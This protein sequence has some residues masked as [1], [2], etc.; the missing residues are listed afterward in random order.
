MP[1][2]KCIFNERWLKHPEYVSWLECGTDKYSAK[3]NICLKIFDISN[4]GEPAIRSHG[5]GSKHKQ[6]LEQKKAA[7]GCT[8]RDFFSGSSKANE[9]QGSTAAPTPTQPKPS[10]APLT[11]FVSR[12]DCLT[13]EVL[14]TL[15]V[16]NSHNSFNSCTDVSSLFAQMFPDSEIAKHFSCGERKCA[17]MCNYGIAPYFKHQLMKKNSDEDGYVLLF[18]ESLNQNTKNKQ[19]D[20]HARIWEKDQVL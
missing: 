4:M 5:K 16:V 14:W 20:I 8:I 11:S 6:L 7:G 19:M 1:P 10:T 13:S 3:C 2:G 17:Y 15:K 9:G 18:D 12:N